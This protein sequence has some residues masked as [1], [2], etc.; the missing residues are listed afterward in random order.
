M[1]QKENQRGRRRKKRRR[2]RSR[3]RRRRKMGRRR[4]NGR[5]VQDQKPPLEHVG[6]GSH[7]GVGIVGSCL[8]KP[9]N[10]LHGQ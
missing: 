8:M 3:K 1:F 9:K 2:K 6:L 4:R 5:F 7:S 10:E